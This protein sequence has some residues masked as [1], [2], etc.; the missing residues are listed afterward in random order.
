MHQLYILPKTEKGIVTWLEKVTDE[1]YNNS[2]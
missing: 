1:E 2:N